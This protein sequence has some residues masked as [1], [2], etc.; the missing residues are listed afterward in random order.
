[1]V[2]Q[3]LQSGAGKFVTYSF[4]GNFESLL[5]ITGMSEFLKRYIRI[6]T[7]N[8]NVRFPFYLR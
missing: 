2:G 1:M 8:R 3:G 5:E 6:A 4:Y 7:S